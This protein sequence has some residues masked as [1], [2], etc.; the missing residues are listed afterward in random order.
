[1]W[2]KKVSELQSDIQITGNKITGTLH[3][4]SGFTDF[5]SI[6]EQQEGHYLVTKY[7]PDPEDADVHVL[8]TDGTV[9]DQILDPSD[10]TLVSW[11]TNKD[12]QKIQVYV[13]KD[14]VRSETTEF[15]LSGL[16]LEE[17]SI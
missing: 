8:K 6:P 16:I 3:Y 2:S 10:L 12:T 14:G 17:E 13:E 1:M 9:G 7:T 15:D 4:I 5:S 11:I